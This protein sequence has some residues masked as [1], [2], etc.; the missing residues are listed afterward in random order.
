MVVG[1]RPVN[2]NG[3]RLNEGFVWDRATGYH[4]VHHKYYLPDD[5]GWW[6]ASWYEHGEKEFRVFQ[7]GKAKIGFLICTEL[8]FG[9]HAREYALQGIHLLVC[10][11]ATGSFSTDKWIAGGRTAAVVSGAYCLSSNFSPETGGTPHF[12]G[13]GWIIEPEDGSVLGTTSLEQPFLTLEID[14]SVAEAAKQTYPRYV[15]D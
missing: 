1:T 3:K 15:S 14:L 5:E 11:R 9:A 8:W 13:C 4:A 12:G 6:E 2:R 7:T 10:P